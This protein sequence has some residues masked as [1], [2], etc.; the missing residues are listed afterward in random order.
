MEAAAIKKMIEPIRKLMP[1][2]GTEK[3]HLYILP[4]L[5]EENI[6]MGRDKFLHFCRER[7]LLIPI[8]KQFHI[9]TDSK[10]FFY[11]SPNLIESLVP[12][13]AEE[14]FVSNISYIK[15]AQGYAYLALVTDLY[16]KKIMGYS[17]HHNMKVPM[18]KE[19]L[20]MALRNRQYIHENVIHH[21]DRGIQ[22]CC[23]DYANYAQQKG[24]VLSTTEKY[25][26]YQNAVAERINGILKY[27]FVLVKT[28]PNLRTAKQMIAEAVD[29]YNNKRRHRSLGMI[30]PNQAHYDNNHLYKFYDQRKQTA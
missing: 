14:V 11:K 21:S 25:D 5:K 7:H 17:V 27:E 18:V 15:L 1:R 24:M 13:H 6:K 22:Y 19:A 28:I 10:H 26:P 2:Y 3:L 16:S 23:P 8:T 12:T 4:A 30:T 9:T 20:D 29:L